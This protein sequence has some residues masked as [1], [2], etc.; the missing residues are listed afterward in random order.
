M[1]KLQLETEHKTQM[2][3]LTNDVKEAVITS[4]VKDGIVVV[5]TPHTTA[6]I[7]LFGC[8]C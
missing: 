2:I 3:N 5:F 1:T 8:F 6:S 4:G 7:T